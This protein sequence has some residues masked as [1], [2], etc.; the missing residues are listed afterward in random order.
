MGFWN[1]V[2]AL[3]ASLKAHTRITSDN[4]DA[5]I[6]RGIGDV[7]ICCGEYN[8][9]IIDRSHVTYALESVKQSLFSPRSLA[10]GPELPYYMQELFT[11]LNRRH[12]FPRANDIL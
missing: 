1:Y 7:R 5:E 10:H 3:N 4:N 12:V 11:R 6:P 2:A 9:S 8:G